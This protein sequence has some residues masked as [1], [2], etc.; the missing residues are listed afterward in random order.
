MRV[1][2]AGLAGAMVFAVP[3]TGNTAEMSAGVR[4]HRGHYHYTRHYH[5]YDCYWR[6]SSYDLTRRPL[7]WYAS[8]PDPG[9]RTVI[10]NREGFTQRFTECE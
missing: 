7:Y 9:C 5:R 1:L 6:C 10:T 2:I 8:F 4:H 3:N